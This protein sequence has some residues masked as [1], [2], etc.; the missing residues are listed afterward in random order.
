MTNQRNQTVGFIGLGAMGGPMAANL[1]KK[2]H[3]LVVY[4]LDS[5]KNAHFAAQGAEVAEGPA[6]V[7]RQAHIVFTMVDTTEQSQDVIVCAGGIVDGA[8]TGD[9]VV[10]MSTIDPAAIVRMNGTLAAKGIGIIDA[11]VAGMIKGAVE[12]TLRTFVGGDAATLDLCRPVMASM[13]SEILHIGA[14]GQGM[15]MKLINNMLYKINSIAAIEAMVLGVKAGL[16]PKMMLDAIGNSTGNSPAFQY[17]ARRMIE[18][19]FEGVRLDI[20]YKDLVLE[21]AL[22]RTYQVPLFLSNVCLQ[23][24]EMGRAAGLGS[25]D[26]TSLVQIYEQITGVKVGKEPKGQ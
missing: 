2:G 24:F 12:G 10:C 18:R 3:R 23:I 11:P 1:L 20:S 17:R 22:G 4:D 9:A 21:T 25:R 8:E 16:D 5:K 6:D 26:A 7:S 14:H 13:C 19:N 15:T